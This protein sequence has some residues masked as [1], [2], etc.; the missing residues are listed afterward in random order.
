MELAKGKAKT[1]Y[2]VK[3]P[4]LRSHAEVEAILG[5]APKPAGA[6]NP[7][8]LTIA[9]ECFWNLQGDRSKITALATSDKTVGDQVSADPLILR[10]IPVKD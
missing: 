3:T 1:L 5:K 2:G 9:D 10:G 4:E 6:A 8:P 7:R